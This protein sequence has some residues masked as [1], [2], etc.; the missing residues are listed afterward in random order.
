MNLRDFLPEL[1]PAR[2]PDLSERYA[3][4]CL[5][6]SVRHLCRETLRLRGSLTVSVND[7]SWV[8][9]AY[10]ESYF[11]PSSDQLADAYLPDE[12]EDTETKKLYCV[13]IMGAYL[14]RTSTGETLRP[15]EVD[16][17]ALRGEARRLVGLVP[18]G[19]DPRYCADAQ[20]ALALWPWFDQS[21]GWDSLTLDMALMPGVQEFEKVALPPEAEDAVVQGALGRL[22]E[23]A[24]R[25]QNLLL[26][27]EHRARASAALAA[28]RVAAEIGTSGTPGAGRSQFAFKVRSTSGFL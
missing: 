19:Q 6:E 17:P 11:R 27:R 12:E 21:K 1:F 15:T 9:G 13:R 20:G 18:P 3:M 7:S 22:F 10:N 8:K 2:R 14:T 16:I 5:R 4:L 23:F 28:L 25:G 24:G 26:A